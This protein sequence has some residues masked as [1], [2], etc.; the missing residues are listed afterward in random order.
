[1]EQKDVRIRGHAVE[2]RINAE[3]P[4]RDFLPIAGEVEFFLPPGGPGV[5]IDS[6][7]YSGYIL[8]TAYDSLLA[9]VVTWAESREEALDRMHRALH[10]CIITGIKTTIPFHLALLDDPLFR[11]GAISTG[12]VTELLQRK[13]A[14][15]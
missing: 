11:A 8:P 4:E 7:L 5:R 6:H 10:E 9:K 3:D 2:C 1:M 14:Q 12:Y 15:S 13:K